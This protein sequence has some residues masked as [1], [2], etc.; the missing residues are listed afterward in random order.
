METILE[1][2]KVAEIKEIL[3]QQ[4]DLENLSRLRKSSAK[5]RIAKI[6]AIE[7]YL[8]QPQKQ[9][10]WLA[11]LHKD[12]G[13]CKE[14]ALITELSP[15]LT[16]MAH[17]YKELKY[18][19]MDEPVSS[20]WVMAGLKGKIQFEPKGQVLVI[21]PW[22]YPLQLAINPLIHAIAAGNAVV[23]KPSEIAAHTSAFLRQMVEE[24]FAAQDVAVVEGGIPET[25]YLLE[26]PFHHIFFTG[27]PAVGKIV[28]RAAANHLTSVT[29]ELGGKSPL[30]FDGT[31]PMDAGVAKVVFGK[32]VNVGQTCI[33]PDYV[34]L[35]KAL[36]DDFIAAFA[37]QVERFYGGQGAAMQQSDSY[38]R[39]IDDKNFKRLNDL[40]EDALEKG[41]QLHM[42]R[43]VDPEHKFMSPVLLSNVTPEMKVMQEEIFGPILP[44]MTYDNLAEVPAILNDFEKPLALYMISKNKK[45]RRFILE[46]TTSGGAAVNE[47][48]VTS[49]NPNLPFGGVNFSGIGKSN[50]RYSFVEFSNEKGVVQRTWGSFS[51]VYPPYNKTLVKWLSRIAKW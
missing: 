14:E 47:L 48:M 2:H 32:C 27:S 3:I 1:E 39:I 34:L 17:I 41:A 16:A 23:L 36:K 30:I 8:L 28:M 46:N 25:T 31:Y 22:N 38:G 40:L 26:Y 45:N 42:E 4:R 15:I 5:E 18:W 43:G 19:M 50:G 9:E 51:I 11:A 35:P 10:L 20:P 24:L 21:A 33:A 37:K 13:K 29:L 12:L 44:V 49:I 7:K 6:K